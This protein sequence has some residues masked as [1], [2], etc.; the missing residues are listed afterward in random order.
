MKIIPLAFLSISIAF[1]AFASESSSIGYKTVELALNALKNKEGTN[2]SIQGGWTII[3][4]KEESNLVLW[5]FTP[6]SH[7]AHPAAIKR[8]VVEKNQKIYIQMS[9]LC[10][11]KKEDCDKLMQE[12]EQLNQNIMKGSR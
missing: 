11:A 9:A 3:E 7:P 5:S 10:Q 8:K 4:D 2:L 12:F 6:D 1:S